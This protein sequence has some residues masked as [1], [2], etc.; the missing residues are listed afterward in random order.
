MPL[1]KTLETSGK[2]Y[3]RVFCSSLNTLSEN[4]AIN[5]IWE[6]NSLRIFQLSFC[7]VLLLLNEFL[8]ILTRVQSG[9][10]L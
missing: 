6:D 9:L 2:R 7:V 3:S 5:Q 4:D 10:I 1:R 8:K